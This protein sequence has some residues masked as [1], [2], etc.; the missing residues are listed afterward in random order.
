MTQVDGIG[1]A[2][3]FGLSVSEW[4]LAWAQCAAGPMAAGVAGLMTARWI[5]RRDGRSAAL[6]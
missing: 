1:W 5:R 4:M 3:T 2:A 6:R